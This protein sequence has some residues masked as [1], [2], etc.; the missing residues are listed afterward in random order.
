MSREYVVYGALLILS[1]VAAYL[2]S[3]ADKTVGERAQITVF[4]VPLSEL[5]GGHY[6]SEAQD[7]S[8]TRTADGQRLL[9]RQVQRDKPSKTS[10]TSKTDR[11]TLPQPETKTIFL[12]NEDFATVFASFTP[13]L[14]KRVL[15]KAS[16]ID[17][18][19]FGLQ[20]GQARLVLQTKDKTRGS[21]E[22]N[23]GKKSY[24]S[25]EFYVQYDGMVY[26]VTGRSIDKIARARAL[27]FEEQLLAV[28]FTDGMQAELQADGNSMTA[29]LQ[30]TLAELRHGRERHKSDGKWLVHGKEQKQFG[31]WLRR[32]RALEVM[33]Y[34]EQL[35]A[36]AQEVMT[37]V[38]R[39]D[40]DELERLRFWH[41][42]TPTRTD[43]FFGQSKFSGELYTELPAGRM[44]Q[45]THDLRK[46]GFMPTLK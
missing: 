2:S 1:L 15:G 11:A 36:A 16:T 13:L 19:L 3:L 39:Q 9:V 7:F 44:L 31:N 40:A 8:L 27:L 23:I 24:G 10:E 42:Q 17:L 38:L 25:A 34:R 4:N 41:W 6:Y 5:E 33:A 20:T 30:G 43:V 18:A 45:L 28:A 26:L 37:L 35:P 32:L 46:G 29:V 12:A 21:I 22:L 14:A